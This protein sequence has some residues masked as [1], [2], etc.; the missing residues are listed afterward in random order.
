MVRLLLLFASTATTMPARAMGLGGAAAVVAVPAV[1]ALLTLPAATRR[2]AWGS[3]KSG[4]RR[5]WWS[6]I[7]C[8]NVVD[9]N[10][11]E[12]E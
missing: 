12:K 3:D 4:R 6:V 11:R 8:G 10:L 7:P 1:V 5:W 9:I 2:S